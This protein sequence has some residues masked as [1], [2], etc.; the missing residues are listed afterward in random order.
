MI[1]RLKVA[2]ELHR[3]HVV[4]MAKNMRPIWYCLG[5]MKEMINTMASEG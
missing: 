5:Y 2:S 1:V 3:S 4:F